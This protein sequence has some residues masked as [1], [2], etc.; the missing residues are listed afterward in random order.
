MERLVQAGVF[1]P[2]RGDEGLVTTG[3]S[4]LLRLVDAPPLVG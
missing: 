2:D 4:E 3:L 1:S